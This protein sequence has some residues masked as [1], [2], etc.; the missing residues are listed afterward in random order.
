MSNDSSSDLDSR[1]A[2]IVESSVG[3]MRDELL[4]RMQDTESRL[5]D[6]TGRIGG[7]GAATAPEPSAAKPEAASGDGD[8]DLFDAVVA[9]DRGGS[10]QEVL[11]ALLEGVGRFAGRSALFLTRADG[12][13]GW[14]SYGFEE[15]AGDMQEVVLSYSDGPLAT[16][17]EGRGCVTLTADECADLCRT[18]GASPGT[19]GLLVPFVLRDRL[20]AALYVDRFA[21]DPPLGRRSLQLLAYVGALAVEG[22]ALRQRSETPT[23]Q[24][25]TEEADAPGVA[26][27]EAPAAAPPPPAPEPV[28]E[29]V[30]L[31]ESR[32]IKGASLMVTTLTVA[33]A[34]LLLVNPSLAEKVICRSVPSRPSERLS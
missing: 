7:E 18:M 32:S 33:V 1:I 19:E 3:R 14:G 4:H 13:Q 34:T 25:A 20:A 9:M 29:P 2:A 28:P 12:A 16:L 6:I 23:L 22:L 5:R 21:D 24:V 30:L 15:T 31:L 10:Q 11:A 17:A 27:W 26:L 8:T